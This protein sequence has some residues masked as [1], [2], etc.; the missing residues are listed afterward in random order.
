LA[1]ITRQVIRLL[2]ALL[3]LFALACLV[4]PNFATAS[5]LLDVLRQAAFTGIIAYGMTLFIVAGE[6][7]V[8]VGSAIAFSSALFGTLVVTFDWPL[9]LAVLA[10]V[11]SGTCMGAGAGAIRAFFNVPSFIVTLAMFSALRGAAMHPRGCHAHTDTRRT[12]SGLG[13]RFGARLSCARNRDAGHILC[14]CRDHLPHYV[15]ALRVWG[16]M[17]YLVL[18]LCQSNSGGSRRSRACAGLFSASKASLYS[19]CQNQVVA[20]RVNSHVVR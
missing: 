10:V 14:I 4:A 19:S 1:S 2:A 12:L 3:L 9:W 5:N 6:I 7:D 13:Q 15:R 18:G 8:S 11:L 20:G 16:R 17:K